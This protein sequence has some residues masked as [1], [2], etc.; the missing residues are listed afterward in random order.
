[1]AANRTV[2]TIALVMAIC[3]V[4]VGCG[5]D[6]K[7]KAEESGPPP[8]LLGRENFAVVQE[9]TL[10]T[11]P[12]ISGSLTAVRE[13]QVRAETNGPVREIRA[14]AG[15][16]VQSGA[17]LAKLDDTAL[18]DAYLSARAAERSAEVAL[19]DAKR[20][21]ERDTRL[22]QAGAI[23]ERDLERSGTQVATAEAAR[24]DARS[25]LVSAQEQLERTTV[26]APFAGVVSE[27]GI[28]RGDVVQSGALLYTVV[29]P[30]SMQL[31]ATVPAD[32]LQSLRLRAPVEF[33]VSG[34]GR[35]RFQGRID[36]INPSVDPATRQ[37]RIYVTIPNRDQGLVTGLFAEGRVESQRRR[38]PAIPLVALDPKGSSNEVLR[39]Q[40]ARVRR[41]RVELGIRDLAAELVEV[42]SGLSVGD[43]VLLGSSQGLADGT[44][45]RIQGESEVRG[46]AEQ[47]TVSGSS[48]RKK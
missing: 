10:A 5:G 37:V 29:D 40:S 22:H 44:V 27:R 3:T 33:T 42:V 38:A 17:V 19:A 47:E 43:T 36:R 39:L 24:A 1:M 23:A 26:R 16:R 30:S 12:I 6:D 41:A 18:N 9:T 35:R 48:V 15:Q 7:A 11:G 28:S 8:V 4:A 31:E 21:L 25:R 46:A 13:A 34:F 2:A 14:E 32:Q 20:D 45:V